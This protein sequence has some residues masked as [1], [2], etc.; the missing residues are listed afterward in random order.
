MKPD[1][2]APGR[3]R[4]LL[5]PLE[6]HRLR[7]LQR[8]LDGR[9]A[10]RRRRRPALVGAPDL[11]RNIAATKQALTSTANPAVGGGGTGCGGSTVVPNNHFGWGLVDA[12]AAYNGAG[13]PR[14]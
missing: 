5:G 12:L 14:P 1:I 9:P 10:R 6:R 7:D 13:T 3:Q 11:V 8:H 2:V 4:A